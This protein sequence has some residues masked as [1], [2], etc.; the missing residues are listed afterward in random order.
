MS[1]AS[2]QS[3][4]GDPLSALNDAARLPPALTQLE[5]SNEERALTVRQPH[6]FL[7]ER[8]SEYQVFDFAVKIPVS[9]VSPSSGNGQ[10]GLD[11]S[12]V[13]QLLKEFRREGILSLENPI[14][15]GLPPEV[16]VHQLVQLLNDETPG[17][18]WPFKLIC[19]DGQHRVAA[20]KKFDPTCSWM[21]FV[22][23]GGESC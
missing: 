2:N 9:A 8:V 15:V 20:A 10:R 1:Q 11:R 19:I 22:L 16:Q 23:F 14:Y 12:H 13:S 3:H 7:L 5:P 6:R 4:P 18:E 21:A 17:R